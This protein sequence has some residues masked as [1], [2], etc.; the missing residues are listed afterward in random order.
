MSN[1][2]AQAPARQNR[3]KGRTAGVFSGKSLS[4]WSSKS[5]PC[6]V[7]P[8]NAAGEPTM[9]ACGRSCS[10]MVETKSSSE[11]QMRVS[12]YAISTNDERL[13]SRRCLATASAGSMMATTLRRGPSCERENSEVVS[14]RFG[15]DGLANRDAPC[16]RDGTSGPRGLFRAIQESISSLIR[17]EREETAARKSAA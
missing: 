17:Q 2:M 5:R 3:G 14:R 8:R 13:T 15:A 10:F 16:S 4:T 9:K 12:R 7:E 11:G 6:C 1:E